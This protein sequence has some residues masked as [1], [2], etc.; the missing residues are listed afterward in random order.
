MHLKNLVLLVSGVATIAS[1]SVIDLGILLDPVDKTLVAP[2]EEFTGKTFNMVKTVF[3]PRLVC[4]RKERLQIENIKSQIVKLREKDLHD[5][6][7][8]FIYEKRW[9]IGAVEK[10][11]R[12]PFQGDPATCKELQDVMET[13]QRMA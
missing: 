1:A 2:V 9:N 8:A 12:I 6:Y 4:T 11:L 5:I 13:Y 3:Q 10:Q 7:R